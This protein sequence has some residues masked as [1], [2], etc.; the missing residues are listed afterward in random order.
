[1]RLSQEGCLASK[2]PPCA[3]VMPS[4]APREKHDP[5]QSGC[6]FFAYRIALEGD[7]EEQREVRERDKGD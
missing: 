3:F 2:L 6:Q 7:Q 1:M 5:G 4:I